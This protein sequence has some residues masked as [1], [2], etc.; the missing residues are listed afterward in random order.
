MKFTVKT[1]NSARYEFDVDDDETVENLKQMIYE[2]TK[3]DPSRQRLIFLGWDKFSSEI[4]HF[5]NMMHACTKDK[6]SCSPEKNSF[7]TFRRRQ[8]ISMICARRMA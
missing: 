8:K 4:F 1:I 7:G 2:K 6:V 5:C 3:I